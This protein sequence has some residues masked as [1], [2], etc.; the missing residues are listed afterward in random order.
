MALRPLA[1]PPAPLEGSLGLKRL[2]WVKDGGSKSRR[3]I[4]SSRAAWCG[5]GDPFHCLMRGSRRSASNLHGAA[6]WL[7]YLERVN[8]SVDIQTGTSCTTNLVL[9][10][11]IMGGACKQEQ[12]FANTKTRSECPHALRPRSASSVFGTSMSYRNSLG[13][14]DPHHPLA[15]DGPQ[16]L[17]HFDASGAVFSSIDVLNRGASPPPRNRC[18]LPR[19]NSWQQG[20]PLCVSNIS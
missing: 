7:L 5:S 20:R 10:A 13:D 15:A 19:L 2:S 16:G 14:S 12:Q 3:R 1:Q 6:F 4:P 11:H 18:P 9:I 8:Y 17:K